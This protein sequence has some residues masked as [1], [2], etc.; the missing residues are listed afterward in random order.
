M[1]AEG[2]QQNVTPHPGARSMTFTEF[3]DRIPKLNLAISA[4]ALALSK[5]I[6]RKSLV[7]DNLEWLSDA[8]VLVCIVAFLCVFARAIQAQAKKWLIV[9]AAASLAGLLAMR[10]QLVEHFDYSGDSFNELRGW[11][12]SP[13]GAMAKANL[14]R[15]LHTSLSLHDVIYYSGHTLMVDLFGG[16]WYLAAACYSFCFLAFLFSVISVAG[17]FELDAGEARK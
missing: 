1:Q 16:S 3:L 17:V 2:V 7:P 6:L 12:L 13:Y 5:T 8:A 4:A 10:I 9:L 11:T 14:E 15:S